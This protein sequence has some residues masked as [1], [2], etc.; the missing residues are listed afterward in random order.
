MTISF[1]LTSCGGNAALWGQYATPT[2]LSGIIPTSPPL[3]TA[4][5]TAVPFV[6]LAATQ[7]VVPT[8]TFGEAF[9]TQEVTS[10][11]TQST[12]TPAANS[13]TL[14]YYTQSGDW[15]PAVAIRFGV[16]ISEIV[17]PKI[18]PA[19]GLLDT[20]TLLIIPDTIDRSLPFTPSV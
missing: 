19:K 5:E 7:T 12:P 6:T 11:L 16:D 18:L 15:L 1:L 14:L 4:T 10:P 9:I 13:P 20:G 8:P 17:S 3:P 2:A